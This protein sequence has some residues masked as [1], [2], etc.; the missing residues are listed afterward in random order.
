MLGPTDRRHEGT[1]APGGPAG[2]PGVN[3]FGE[4]CG[5]QEG[6]TGMVLVGP[7]HGFGL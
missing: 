5:N 6:Y 1:A 2:E 7:Y 3:G 4:D